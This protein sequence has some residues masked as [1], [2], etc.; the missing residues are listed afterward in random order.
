MVTKDTLRAL[1]CTD[2]VIMKDAPDGKHEC[3]I[4][5]PEGR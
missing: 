3:Q 2:R 1:Y 5:G 4:K